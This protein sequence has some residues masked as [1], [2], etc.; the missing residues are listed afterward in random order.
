MCQFTIPFPGSPEDLINRAQR[1]IESAG[2]SFAGDSMQGNF[3]VKT[4]I[5]AVRGTYLMVP[6]GISVTISKK[7]LLV[8]CSRIE[9]ELREVMT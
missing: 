2:G 1:E 4:P 3:A 9:K 5:G 8:S 6:T 7:P